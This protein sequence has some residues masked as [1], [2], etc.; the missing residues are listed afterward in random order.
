MDAFGR[1]LRQAPNAGSAG[2]SP[3][4]PFQEPER[5]K[6]GRNGPLLSLDGNLS[7]GGRTVNRAKMSP[8]I[9]ATRS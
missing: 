5:G 1:R 8:I 2:Q 9:V 3:G 4:K 7:H 6:S